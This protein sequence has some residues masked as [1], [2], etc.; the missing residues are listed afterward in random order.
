MENSRNRLEHVMK[1]EITKKRIKWK[2]WN[3]CSIQ[4]YIRKIENKRKIMLLEQRE[5][6]KERNKI[7]NEN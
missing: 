7:K 5:K 4:K 2:R 6:A 3:E 1:D